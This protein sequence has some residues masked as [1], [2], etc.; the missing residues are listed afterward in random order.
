[1]ANGGPVIRYRTLSDL[2]PD[3]PDYSASELILNVKTSPKVTVWLDLN[4]FSSPGSPFGIHGS[5]KSLYENFIPKMIQFGF[6]ASMGELAS[7]V[8]FYSS[9]IDLSRDWGILNLVKTCY[10]ALTVQFGIIDKECLLFLVNR[11][12]QIFSFVKDGSYDIY[13]DP[14]NYPSIPVSLRNRPLLNPDLYISNIIPVPTIYDV[15]AAKSL[16]NTDYINS[17]R[18]NTIIDYIFTDHFDTL[19]PEYGIYY[20]S[21]KK[22]FYA[23]GWKPHLENY[24]I[25]TAPIKNKSL[26]LLQLHI[27][28]HFPLIH[29]QNWFIWGMEV[30]ES[31]KTDRGTY[32]LPKEFLREKS[33]GYW[34]NGSYMGLGENRQ[35]KNWRE[36][37]STFWILSIKKN[38]NNK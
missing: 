32:I 36:L 9:K 23:H 16:Y 24:T 37:E 17:N 29:S 33:S 2:H 19:H 5:K 1:L 20:D 11:L 4:P 34:V 10:A 21:T 31:Y 38:L 6:N 26:F 27:F 35:S 18:I 13:T 15:L 28:S 14:S 3:P 30:L 25:Q 22:R 7:Y 12:N 8:S